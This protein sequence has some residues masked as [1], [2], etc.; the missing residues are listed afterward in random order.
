MNAKWEY[1]SKKCKE[2]EELDAMHRTKIYKKIKEFNRM[3]ARIY[4]RIQDK[5]GKLLNEDKQVNRWE[6]YIEEL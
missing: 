1:Y 4:L 3:K 5:S 2:R 6:K